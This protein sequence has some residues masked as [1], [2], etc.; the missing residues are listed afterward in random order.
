MSNVQTLQISIPSLGLT[1]AECASFSYEEGVSRPFRL[2]AIFISSS[3]FTQDVVAGKPATFHVR[4][5]ESEQRIGGVVLEFRMLNKLELNSFTYAVVLVPRLALL[6][7]VRQNEI[8]ATDATMDLRA[9]LTGVLDGS[10]SKQATEGNRGFEVEATLHD[11]VKA[12]FARTHITKFN[13]S[14]LQFF[15]RTCEH[16]GVFYFFKFEPTDGGVKDVVTVAALNAAF[17]VA[18]PSSVRFKAATTTVSVSEQV[19]TS[20]CTRATPALQRFNLRDY[21]YDAAET[22]LLVQS[23]Q[24]S[25]LGSVV[26]YGDNYSNVDDGNKLLGYRLEEET[27]Q[28]EVFEFESTLPSIRSGTVVTLTEHPVSAFNTEYVVIS[29]RHSA[30]QQGADGYRAGYPT[31]PYSNAFTAIRKS[32]QFRPRR[33][34][35]KPVMPGVFNAMLEAEDTSATRAVLDDKG[36]YRVKL[37]YNEGETKNKPGKGSGPV[38]QAQPYAGASANSVLAGLHLPMVRS[39]EVLVGYENGDPDRPV[40]LGGAFNSKN[41]NPVNNTTQTVNRLRTT[42]GL[43]LELDDGKTDTDPRYIRF[44]VPANVSDTP[45][46]GTYMRMGAQVAGDTAV[47]SGVKYSSSTVSQ[48]G[49]GW[50]YNGGFDKASSNKQSTSKSAV[51]ATTA[52]ASGNGILIY[53]DQDMDTNILGAS[54]AKIQK[55][56]ATEVTEGDVT[57]QVD[58]GQFKLTTYNG[59]SISAGTVGANTQM[60]DIKITATNT[61]STKSG[62]DT[63]QWISGTS[64]KYTMGES[65][66]MFLGFEQTIKAAISITMQVSGYNT[67]TLGI[68]TSMTIGAKWDM[69]V[70]SSYK[71]VMGIGDKKVTATDMKIT[72]ND[73]KIAEWDTK[74]LGS[75]D[76]KKCMLSLSIETEKGQKTEAEF[77]AVATEFLNSDLAAAKKAVWSRYVNLEC[78]T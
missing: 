4:V 70:G 1:D 20:L 5:N 48:E 12:E 36:R 64:T 22:D 65:F 50:D 71:L 33:L 75:F 32:R 45:P 14:D 21:A 47:E 3:D 44:D 43:L 24:S 52:S 34:T 39:A 56:Q 16:Y 18:Q 26:E 66:S 63:Y 62:G 9:L 27:W 54:V 69:I 29:V 55:G 59:V 8:F 37:Y 67:T 10:L 61:V 15:S 11:S 13:E 23:Q 42:G 7:R 53:T 38:R 78:V 40:I 35:P 28:T 73:F 77:K 46:T 68:Y 25:G 51:N 76:L 58:Q 72:G 30:G 19:I 17:D 41:K 2:E 60:A 31:L 74:I 49:Q 6:D 57:C